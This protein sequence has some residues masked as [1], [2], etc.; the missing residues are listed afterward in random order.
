MYV[1]KRICL[2]LLL[3]TFFTQLSERKEK[4]YICTLVRKTGFWNPIGCFS[5]CWVME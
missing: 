2:L 1:T 3:K 5:I 4:V